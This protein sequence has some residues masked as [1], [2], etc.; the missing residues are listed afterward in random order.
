MRI[1]KGQQ[2]LLL[3]L[4]YSLH[5]GGGGR[6]GS[7]RRPVREEKRDLAERGSP[8]PR[9]NS[10]WRDRRGSG[11]QPPPPPRIPIEK[12]L[13]EGGG[14]VTLPKPLALKYANADRTWGWQWVFPAHR[15]Y[16][17]SNTGHRHRHHV[18]ETTL[19]RAV[20][21]ASRLAARSLAGALGLLP[22]YEPIDTSYIS[23]IYI[24]HET[25]GPDCEV[26]WLRLG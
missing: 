17:D 1:P 11:G 20:K 24:M 10:R 16:E 5:A 21:E 18:D 26:Y 25:G 8:E 15:Q 9:R 6:T 7:G 19:Q 3:A 4:I 2:E 23:N 12:D 13:K 14:Y 22:F